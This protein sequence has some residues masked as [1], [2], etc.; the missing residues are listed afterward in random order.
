MD[1]SDNKALRDRL[2][3]LKREHRDLDGT[4]VDLTATGPFDQLLVQRLK[5][6][7]LRL[8]DEIQRLEDLLFPD[9]IA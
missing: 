7:K 8:K 9:I 3:A 6:R 1:E 4:I 2:A 5:R